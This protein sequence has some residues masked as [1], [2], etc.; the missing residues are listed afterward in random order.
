M[1]IAVFDYDTVPTNPYGKG[2]L[3]VLE[4]LCDE[5]E[6]TVYSPSFENPRPDRITW[7][8]VR[9]LPRPLLVLFATF[10]LGAW[11]ALTF[12]RIVRRRRFDL[13]Q[14]LESASFGARVVGVQFCH[15]AYLRHHWADS[16]PRGVRRPVRWLYEWAA[17]AFE[18]AVLGRA[19]VVVVPSEGLAGELTAQYPSLG[20]RIVVVPNAIDWAGAQSAAG[21]AGAAAAAEVRRRHGLHPDRVLVA[22]VALGHFERKG[23]PLVLDALARCPDLDLD[24][25]V[26]GGTADLVAGYAHGV[27]Q[28][29]LADRVTFVGM[30]RDPR[31][32]LWAA[33][34]FVFPSAYETFSYVTFEAAAAG[35]PV[36]VS[37]LHGVEGFLVDGHTGVLVE[38]TAVSVEAA[39]RRVA[40]LGPDGRR[41]LGARARDAVRSYDVASYVA[42]WARAY[43][44]AARPARPSRG[45]S[46]RAST[47]GW[48][49]R[50]PVT[51]P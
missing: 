19:R 25:V 38:R 27:T 36:I 40:A 2:V 22:F 17:A 39:L 16:R 10:H 33:D 45:A 21:E 42:G 49:R 37:R 11:W 23:L 13:V 1:R 48:R 26:V 8:R 9:A 15:R 34:A 47:A 35:L 3:R 20:D 24:L 44:A 7:R 4:G 12:D 18:P 46:G 14:G 32:L 51:S 30:Q 31:P 5:H 6:F 50:P 41:D 28:A 43:E 29:G